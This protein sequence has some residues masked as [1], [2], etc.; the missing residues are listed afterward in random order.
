MKSM[1]TL[2]LRRQSLKSKQ[3]SNI[4][5][6]IKREEVKF[7]EDEKQ[8][9]ED[10]LAIQQKLIMYWKVLADNEKKRKRANE[11]KQAEKIKCDAREAEIVSL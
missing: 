2:K 11:K 8:I 10:D 6:L 1:K 9:R 3:I 4:C 7:K 5:N